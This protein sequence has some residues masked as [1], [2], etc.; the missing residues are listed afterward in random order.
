M[1]FFHADELTAG[2]PAFDDDERIELGIFT[3][4]A[5]WRLVANGSA[6]AKTVLALLWLQGGVDKIGTYFGR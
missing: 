4:R 1:H 2:E 3:I 5:A 6:D